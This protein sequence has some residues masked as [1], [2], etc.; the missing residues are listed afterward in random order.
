MKVFRNFKHSFNST[1]QL[2]GI[3]NTIDSNLP[4]YWKKDQNWSDES[5]KMGLQGNLYHIYVYKG[6]DLPEAGL[7]FM[8]SG[9]VLEVVNIIPIQ[10]SELSIDEYNDLLIDFITLTLPEMKGFIT[11]DTADIHTY[12]S[13]ESVK[14]LA[15]FSILANRRTVHHHLSDKENWFRFLLSVY[16]K[17]EYNKLRDDSLRVLLQED[18]GWSEDAADE[19]VLSYREC[20]NLIIFIKKGS[21]V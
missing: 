6:K 3:I 20:I 10:K 5:S 7:C 16:R 8:Q 13:D 21:I 19:L 14:L 9:R 18:Y 17:R 12:L 1:A 4:S 15:N 11:S 2:Q